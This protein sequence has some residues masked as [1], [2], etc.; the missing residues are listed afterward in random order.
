[1][2]WRNNPVHDYPTESGDVNM[3]E[4]NPGYYP[5]DYSDPDAGPFS[6]W[7]FHTVP[8]LVRHGE[9]WVAFS[10]R[11][12]FRAKGRTR[13]EALMRLREHLMSL[14]DR[15]THEASIFAR[16]LQQAIPGIY[17]LDIGL[18][19]QLRETET[20]ED[21]ETIAFPDSELYRQV[22]RRFD[23]SDYFA[24]KALH[25]EDSR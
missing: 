25:K 1:M 10:P 17:A 9:G 4:L 19:H 13:D 2:S 24:K 3:T 21:I 11:D 23:V 14:T 7:A 6:K 8:Q 15:Q 5:P 12:D 16:H 20:N 22:G 18:F